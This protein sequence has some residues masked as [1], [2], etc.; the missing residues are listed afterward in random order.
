MSGTSVLPRWINPA[1]LLLLSRRRIRVS[2][3][4]REDIQ[5]LGTLQALSYLFLS[6]KRLDRPKLGRFVVG[7]DAF[8][9]LLECTLE[10]FPV[11]PSM[12]PR[13]AMPRLQTFRF[14]IDLD[15]FTAGGGDLASAA[16][17]LAL[18]HLPSLRK[19]VVCEHVAAGDEAAASSDGDEVATRVKEKLRHEAGVHPNKPSID[20]RF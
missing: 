20:L 17:D 3:V 7:A 1:V 19:V 13:G 14:H 6:V 4:R 16:D 18:G 15:A 9:C 11:V 2:Q 5:V 10:G 8:R 12:F